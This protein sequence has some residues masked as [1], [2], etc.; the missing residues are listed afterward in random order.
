MLLIIYAR[1]DVAAQIENVSTDA[2]GTGIFGAVLVFRQDF[3]LEDAFLCH[4]CWG[5]SQHTC[6]LKASISR[7]HYFRTVSTTLIASTH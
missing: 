2:Q 3:A 6:H 4:D 5:G 7:V 1:V